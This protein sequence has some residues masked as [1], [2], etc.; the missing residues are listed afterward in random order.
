M[1]YNSN[2]KFKMWAYIVSHSSLL[3]R[4]EMKFPDQ[5]NYTEDQ[6]YNI[7]FEFWAV[8]YI[9]I[10]TILNNIIIKEITEKEVPMEI[11]K[12]LLKYNMK[13]FKLESKEKKYYIIAGG[14][15]IGK[16]QWVNQDRILNS[17]LNLEHDEV[18]LITN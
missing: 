15:L 18:I 17:N 4:S 13:I 12:N 11:D 1:V 9:N 16:N 10:P 6:S 14:L 3:L 8:N 2:R 7:D 5:D